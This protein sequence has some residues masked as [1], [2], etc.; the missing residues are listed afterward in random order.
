MAHAADSAPAQGRK[1]PR[2]EAGDD[3]AEIV[4]LGEVIVESSTRKVRCLEAELKLEPVLC[5]GVPMTVKRGN[6]CMYDVY[7]VDNQVLDVAYL[8][9]IAPPMDSTQFETVYNS[10]SRDGSLDDSDS[11]EDW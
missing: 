5:N 2:E 7:V 6:A 3:D 1:R 10:D 11:E 9:M 4:E 8:D